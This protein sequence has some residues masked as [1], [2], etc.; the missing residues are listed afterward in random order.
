MTQEEKAR[1]YE[2]GYNDAVE[3][4]CVYL[5]IKLDTMWSMTPYGEF[6]LLPICFDDFRKYMEEQR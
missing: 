2:Q 3:K 5:D 4:A 6:Y 1:A